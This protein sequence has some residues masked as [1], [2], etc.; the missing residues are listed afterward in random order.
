M[1][2]KDLFDSVEPEAKEVMKR[3]GNLESKVGSVHIRRK[4]IWYEGQSTIACLDSSYYTPIIRAAV[5]V[6]NQ[7]ESSFWRLRRKSILQREAWCCILRNNA[8][9]PRSL[10][11]ISAKF[12]FDNCRF[13]YL[14]D[15]VSSRSMYLF[16]PV[17]LRF[18]SSLRRI[19]RSQITTV[20][21]ACWIGAMKAS[22]SVCRFTNLLRIIEFCFHPNKQLFCIPMEEWPEIC[23]RINVKMA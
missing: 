7:L 4:R 1:A 19:I 8:Q 23:R 16:L 22:S 5:Q 14:N 20:F 6:E 2:T 21:S 10:A 3:G 17:T 13:F 9:G 12:D 11:I 18:A 15:L